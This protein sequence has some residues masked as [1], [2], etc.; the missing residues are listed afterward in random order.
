MTL[1]DLFNALG[2]YTTATILFFV[3]LPVLA[4]FIGL[5]GGT[6]DHLSPWKYFY[7]V[8]VYLVSIPGVFAV[9][10]NVY[11]FLFQ[12]QDVMQTNLLT[13]IVPILSMVLTVF[14]LKRNIKLDFIPGFD[15]IYGF[16]LMLFSTM[17]LMWLL[18]KIRIV[19][20]SFLPFQYLLGIFGILFLLIYF[21]WR[22]F[23]SNQMN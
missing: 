23:S 17:F 9:G 4:L 15:K 22:R 18:E 20:F 21:G 14:I 7:S 3:A 19:V 10:L 8:I 13:Q 5:V 16:W 11:L 6:K 1:Q 12:R 2:N